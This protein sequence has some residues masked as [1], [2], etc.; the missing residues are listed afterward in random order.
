MITMRGK[1]TFGVTVAAVFT[2][3]KTIFTILSDLAAV[4]APRRNVR[5]KALNTRTTSIVNNVAQP[6]TARYVAAIVD[7]ILRRMACND[8]LISLTT[9]ASESF[10]WRS[11]P[12]SQRSS[13]TASI[14]GPIIHRFATLSSTTGGYKVNVGS[15][16]ILNWKRRIYQ[17]HLSTFNHR[18]EFG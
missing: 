5:R 17:L 1:N 16:G 2:L 4:P 12:I 10:L 9:A 6:A 8:R 13:A 11:N 3:S 7:Q 14:T 18:C 15:R